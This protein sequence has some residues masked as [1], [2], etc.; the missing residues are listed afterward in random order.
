MLD[1][2]RRQAWN[3]ARR[4]ARTKPKGCPG[5]PRKMRHAGLRPGHE[6]TKALKGAGVHSGRTLA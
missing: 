5:R 3:D 1:Q 6:R 2:V 4:L